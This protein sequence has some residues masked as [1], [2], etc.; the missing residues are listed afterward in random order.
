MKKG[1]G[2]TGKL[3]PNSLRIISSCIRTVSTNASTAVRSAGAS[4]AASISS[5]G[6][7]RKEQV[8]IPEFVFKCVISAGA[9]ISVIV[10]R[11][12]IPG[13]CLKYI[14]FI[15]FCHCLSLIEFKTSVTCFLIVE[16]FRIG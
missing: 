8:C 13:Y 6:D 12:A 14:P 15:V 5:P 4:V 9:S 11:L 7:D 10:Y 2:K 1:K 3:L 16:F